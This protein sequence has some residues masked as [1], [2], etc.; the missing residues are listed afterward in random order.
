MAFILLASFPASTVGWLLGYLVTRFGL[1]GWL[2]GWGL[3]L[4]L[5]FGFM[6]YY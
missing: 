5:G 1:L 3:S 4:D 2:P 6:T